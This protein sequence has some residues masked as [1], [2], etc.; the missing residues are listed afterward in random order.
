MNYIHLDLY[1]TKIKFFFFKERQQLNYS[2][3]PLCR[4]S[5]I[6]A[7][8]AA[9]KRLTAEHIQQG[10]LAMRPYITATEAPSLS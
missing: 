2:I 10:Q 5:T 6:L 7:K 4:L 3:K 1:H 8:K 9:A